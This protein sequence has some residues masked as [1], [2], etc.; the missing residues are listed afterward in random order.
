LFSLYYKLHINKLT[1]HI[2][3]KMESLIICYSINCLLIISMII[4]KYSNSMYIAL[5]A[6]YVCIALILLSVVQF[7]VAHEYLTQ[8]K[9]PAN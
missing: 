4:A 8:T 2:T 7:A 9:L 3:A 1:T 5:Y 6:T